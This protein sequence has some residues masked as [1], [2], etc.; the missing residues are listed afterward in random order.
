MIKHKIV[1]F[2]EI[3]AKKYAP[4]LPLPCISNRVHL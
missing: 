1:S 4:R 2:F 3:L